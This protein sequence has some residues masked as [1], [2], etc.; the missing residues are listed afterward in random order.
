MKVVMFEDAEFADLY[1]LVY[2]RPVFGLRCGAFTLY[3]KVKRK[4]KGC[5]VYLETREALDAVAAET[6]GEDVVNARAAL[7]GDDDILL[8]NAATLLTGEASAYAGAE[9]AACTEDGRL[10]WAF[11]KRESV[12]KLSAGSAR[13]LAQ[14]ASSELPR[15]TTD[16][17]LIRYP[18]DLIHNNPGQIC[19]DFAEFADRAGQRRLD[20]LVAVRGD[21]INLHVGEG[22]E[23]QPLTFIDCSEGPVIIDKGARIHAHTS[24]HG[25]AYIGERTELFEARIRGGCSLGPLCRVGGE[26]EESIIHAHSNKYHTGFLGHS[27]VC[28]WVNL[29]ALTTNS[30]LKNDYSNVVV[31]L[32]GVPTDTG[33]IKVGSFIGDHTKTSIGAMLNTGTVVGIVCNLVGGAGVLPKYIPSFAWHVQGRFSKGLGLRQGLKTAQVAMDRRRVELTA[34]MRELITYVERVTRDDRMNRVRR[35]RKRSR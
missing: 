13:E 16:D 4:F 15:E 28:E 8:V 34:G 17:V 19:A 33:A 25:P 10:M 31:S 14:K 18:W 21:R 32:N 20:P 1:P 7:G 6:Y 24:I 5:T 30:D 11:L 23:V 26:V 12:E 2:L 27:Y 35:D 22:A 29:G 9:K 3:E